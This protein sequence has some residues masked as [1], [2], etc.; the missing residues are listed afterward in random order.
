[1]EDALSAYV[2][3][4]SRLAHR[5]D[6]NFVTFTQFDSPGSHLLNNLCDAEVSQSIRAHNACLDEQPQLQPLPE[7]LLSEIVYVIG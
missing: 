1:M 3:L 6:E 5:Y 4:R 2:Y 7:L